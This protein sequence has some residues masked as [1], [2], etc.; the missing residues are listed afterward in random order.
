MESSDALSYEI[1]LSEILI[2]GKKRIAAI[3]PAYNEEKTIG[4][5][6]LRTKALVDEVLVVDDGSKDDTSLLAE[7]A[8]ATVLKM[9]Y[10]SGKAAALLY[11]LDVLA[12]DGFDAVVMLDADGQHN[13][14]QI[15]QLLRPILDDKADMV[16]GSR[17]MEGTKGIPRYRKVGQT[18]LNKA[19]SFGAGIRITDSQSGFRAL[20]KR[21]LQNLDFQSQGYNIETDMIGHFV[22]RGVR[23]TEVPIETEYNVP[24]GHKKAPLPHGMGVLNAAV[25]LIGYRRPL[26]FF[27]IPGLVLFITGMIL[28]LLSLSQNYI[29][30]W[31]W[32]FQ[33]MTAVT[34]TMIG[35]VLVIGGLTLN[36]LVALMHSTRTRV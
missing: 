33:S 25:G 12:E 9:P 10:N 1:D 26:L 13:P 27:G 6:V 7:S 3:I 28:G 16:I 8:G 32:F 17:F 4:S 30:G 14:K 24:N 35:V 23:I 20:S 21:A 2:A 31:G 36:S 15:P 29:F 11:G 5:V 18:V 19:T 22:D 34:L